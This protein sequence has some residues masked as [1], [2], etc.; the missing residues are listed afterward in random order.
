MVKIGAIILLI[1]IF[2]GGYFTNSI[3]TNPEERIF[4]LKIIVVLAIFGAIIFVGY[5]FTS[6]GEEGG[7]TS[8]YGE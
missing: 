2:I 7:E 3:I 4:I 6:G 5:K 8:F 1:L